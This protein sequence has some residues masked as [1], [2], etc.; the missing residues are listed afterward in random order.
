METKKGVIQPDGLAG[1]GLAEGLVCGDRIA[2]LDTL[3]SCQP[4]ADVPFIIHLGVQTEPQ[5]DAV[6][7]TFGYILQID[8]FVTIPEIPREVDVLGPLERIRKDRV[9]LLSALLLSCL[10]LY[11]LFLFLSL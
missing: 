9:L 4:H 6:S 10:L 3:T 7:D 1:P 11:Y 8:R 2:A 5:S